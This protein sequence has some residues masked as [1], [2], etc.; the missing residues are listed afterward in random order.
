M[1]LI[2]IGEEAFHLGRV[3]PSI[4]LRDV[5]GRNAQGR[6][7]IAR[8]FPQCERRAKGHSDHRHDDGKRPAQCRL[9]QSH[10]KA[11]VPTGFPNAG[12][13]SQ[14]R[15]V[16]SHSSGACNRYD[17]N[18]LLSTDRKNRAWPPHGWARFTTA[19]QISF[20]TF[21]PVTAV[22]PFVPPGTKGGSRFPKVITF[23][24]A[25]K[26]AVKD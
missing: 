16:C 2:I 1:V 3:H 5:N 19:S 22:P 20:P 7:N 24:T 11:I 15:A 23:N 13:S 12:T 4:R 21:A 6:K 9:D 18:V 8:H 17:T 25:K 10:R 26:L 14:Q